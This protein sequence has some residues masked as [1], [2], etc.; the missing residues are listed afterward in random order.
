MGKSLPL[1]FSVLKFCGEVREGYG[2]DNWCYGFCENIGMAAVFDGCGGS[3]ARQHRDYADHSEAY[4]ASRLC[5][6]AVY[7]CMQRNFPCNDSTE[8]FVQEMLVTA[9]N[10][11]LKSN[12]PLE[13]PSGIKISGLRTLPSTM[14][15]VLIRTCNDG[16]L[17]VSPIW[18]GDSRVYILD[19][20]GISQL[21]ID[22][23]NQPDPMEG[24]YDDGTL[25]NVLCADKPIKLNCRTIHIRPPFMVI[26]ASDGCFGYVSTPMEFEGMILHTML[27]SCNIA[28]WEDNMQKL[29][30][31]FA[32]D[33][34]TLLLASF[35]FGSFEAIQKS[36]SGRYDELR[37]TYLE[38]VWETPWE[39]RNIRRRLWADYRKNYMKYIESEQK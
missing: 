16:S 39:D 18:A 15:A 26:A 23:S 5:A 14:A 13:S 36:F 21:T 27:E 33:D 1:D 22:D 6:G 31:S 38:T 20:T 8:Q 28:Q 11:R 37:K 2:E 19:A 29:I 35:G 34:H 7:E 24:L 30:A 25:T 17:E 32:G 4:M 10:D 3:G 9:I 12:I